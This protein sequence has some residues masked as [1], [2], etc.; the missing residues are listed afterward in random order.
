MNYIPYNWQIDAEILM[1][2]NVTQ[3]CNLTPID[4]R[5]ILL[6]LLRQFSCG[7]TDDLKVSD[8]GVLGFSVLCESLFVLVRQVCSDLVDGF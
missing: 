1:N 6:Y 3:P 2:E 8:D 4:L 5:F 7:L